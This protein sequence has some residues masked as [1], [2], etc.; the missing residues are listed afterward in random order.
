MGKFIG[1]SGLSHFWGKVKTYVGGVKTS[2]ESAI[3]TSVSGATTGLEAEIAKKQDKLTAGTGISI[4]SDGT[5]GVT[6]DV[7]LYKVVETLPADGIDE[8]KIYLVKGGTSGT[9]NIYIEYMY[10]NS[11]WEKVGEYK[12]DVDLTPY[13]KTADVNT[14]LALKADKSDTYTKSEVDSKVTASGTFSDTEK[15]KLAGIEAGAEVNQN[16]FSKITVGSV[17]AE[18]D[19]ESDEFKIYGKPDALTLT[20]NISMGGY[21]LQISNATSSMDGFMSYEDKAKLDTVEEGATKV[22]VD[23]ALSGTSTNPVQNKVINSAL[24]GKQATLT[25]GTNITISGTTISAKDTTYSAAT[26]SAAGLMSAS[27]YSKLA[28]IATGATA[29]EELTDAEIDEACA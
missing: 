27:D 1:K 18:A 8:N 23:T 3:D 6:L 13:A 4:G 7:T 21:L 20:E 2:L 9:D 28:T 26:A 14:S 11:A 22:V 29:D 15:T 19:S 16:A 12:S 25:A 10:V 5:I 17:T 24:A